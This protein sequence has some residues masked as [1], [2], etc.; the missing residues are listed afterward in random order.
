[1]DEKQEVEQLRR[2]VILLTRT[3]HLYEEIME[4]VKQTYEGGHDLDNAMKMIKIALKA[5]RAGE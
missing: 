3:V 5:G 1:M 2:E 4:M